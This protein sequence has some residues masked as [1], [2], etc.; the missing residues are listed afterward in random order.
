MAR[1]F[2]AQ[3]LAVVKTERTPMMDRHRAASA[4]AQSGVSPAKRSSTD[5]SSPDPCS[6]EA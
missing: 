3:L 5:I 4:S 1:F 6:V 2:H